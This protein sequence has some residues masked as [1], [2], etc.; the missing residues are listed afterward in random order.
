MLK[1]DDIIE[2]EICAYGSAGEGIAKCDGCTVFVERVAKGD[3]VR[4][5][6]TYAKKN[7]AYA[8]PIKLLGAGSGRADPPCPIYGKCGGC[9][10][11]HLVYAEQLDF[12]RGLVKNNLAKIGGIDI[13]VPQVVPSE[14]I[15]RYRNK[16]SVP[17]GTTDGKPAAGLYKGNTH[18]II[19]FDDCLLLQ[20]WAQRI[21]DIVSEFLRGKNLST[22]DEQT[23][24]GFLR[25]VV[26]RCVC[27]QL[28]VTL[29]INAESCPDA[30][31]LLET[32]LAN[33]EKVGLFVN[34]NRE[35]TNVIFGLETTHIGGIEKISGSQSGIDFTLRPQTFY[36]VNEDIKNRIYSKVKEL[37]ELSDAEIMIDAYSGAGI[38]S[39]MLHSKKY[40][41]YAIE[42]EPDAVADAEE[43]KRLNGLGNLTNICGDV[44]KE[45][46][47]IT[48]ENRGKN[49]AL[50]VDPPRKGLGSNVVHT[51]LR[52]R[53]TQI[54][55]ISCDSATLARDLKMLGVCADPENPPTG[56][57]KKDG[58]F[59]A[60]GEEGADS[61]AG[62]ERQ[63]FYNGG[64]TGEEALY[65]KVPGGGSGS[66]ALSCEKGTDMSCQKNSGDRP[67]AI[68][69]QADAGTT[70]ETLRCEK[71][72]SASRICDKVKSAQ[73][74]NSAARNY[75]ITFLQP[76][77]MFPQT[78]HVECVVLMSRVKD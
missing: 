71:R 60:A 3:K 69:C 28:L 8:K 31:K 46:V 11:Q 72:F 2:V 78:R 19:P 53:P 26:A 76:Y 9:Q 40:H 51:I 21:I 35:K 10:L 48:E 32:L 5:K 57:N 68:S 16:M 27:G 4:A 52:A 36:Q 34:F 42:I 62:N 44:E 29:V 41:T 6:V 63:D 37:L 74:S 65:I 50:V 43:M 73:Q 67:L 39:G 30:K 38:L 23:G 18:E 25:H 17:F 75:K 49:I 54:V 33:F 47:K 77:D 1:K 22:Y 55:Y 56:E 70:D 64:N 59:Y 24:A 58:G 61:F 12:K 15:W 20:D 13:G 66:F 45:L 7:I 14:K